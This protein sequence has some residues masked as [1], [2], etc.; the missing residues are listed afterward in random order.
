MPVF[1]QF[2]YSRSRS[3]AALFCFLKPMRVITKIFSQKCVHKATSFRKTTKEKQ[4]IV[5]A[6]FSTYIT[7][8]NPVLPNLRISHA[9]K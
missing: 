6:L 9:M 4:K 1:D 3:R 5:T 2:I 8:R 7:L